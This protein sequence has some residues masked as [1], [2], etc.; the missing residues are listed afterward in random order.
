MNTPERW[1]VSFDPGVV[2]EVVRRVSSYDW[3]AVPDLG[4]WRA[5][6]DKDFLRDLCSYWVTDYSWGAAERDLNA[7]PQFVVE[8][9]GQRLHYLHLTPPAASGPP[10]MLLHGWPGTCF[11]LLDVAQRLVAAGHEVVVPSLPGFVFSTPLAAPVGPRGT[12][13]L[14]NEL[15]SDVLGH[16]TY[17]AHGTD[18]G[19]S[20]ASWLGVD[21]GS[22]CVGVHLGMVFMTAEQALPQAGEEQEW[23]S[24]NR[25]TW[26]RESGYFAVQSTRAQTLAFAMADSPVGTAAWILEKYAAWS[27][28]PRDGE[29]APALWDRYSRDQLLTVVMLYLLT[30]TFPTSTWMYLGAAAEPTVL[31]GDG[32]STPVG[33]AAFRDPVFVPPP[34]SYAE[35]SHRIV[36]WTDMPR[37]GHFPGLE[38]PQLLVADL[39][40][41]LATLDLNGPTILP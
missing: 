40:R 23:A 41:F 9:A 38:A 33:V 5:G 14:F 36:Q 19:S 27:D 17:V 35:Q 22:H 13:R 37:G 8:V 25:A 34:R 3:S 28:L 10:V 21:H 29:G 39:E 32:G 31:P 30:A 15:M 2:R 4:G 1:A 18:W 24:R 20:I 11:E 26:R 16:Q 6:I 7:P 12:A